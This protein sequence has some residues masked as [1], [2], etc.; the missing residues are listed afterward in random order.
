MKAKSA[1]Y[2]E[3]QNLYKSKARRDVAEVA[4][5]ARLLECRLERTTTIGYKEVEAFCKSAGYIKLIRGRLPHIAKPQSQIQWHDQA[6]FAGKSIR[7]LYF[8]GVP[9]LEMQKPKLCKIQTHSSCF[10]SLSSPSTFTPV[11]TAG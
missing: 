2:I 4:E 5:R 6:G 11:A 1:D 7:H 3:L 10:T 8:E 9:D